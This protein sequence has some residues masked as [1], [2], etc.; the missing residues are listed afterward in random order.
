MSA[1]TLDSALC[2]SATSFLTA[3]MPTAL[4]EKNRGARR[5]AVSTACWVHLGANERTV[6]E[7]RSRKTPFKMSHLISSRT[8]TARIA[9]I[10][11]RVLFILLGATGARIGE[12]L[13]VEIDKHISPDF[14]TISIEQKLLGGVIEK[15]LKTEASLRKVDLHPDI[16]TLLKWFVGDRKSGFLFP[17]AC[18]GK[19]ISGHTALNH[20]HKALKG[21]GYEN[22]YDHSSKA[23]THIFRRFR[24]T[25][26]RNKVFCPVGVRHFWV[27]HG[28]SDEDTG[29]QDAMGELYDKIANDRPF[30]LATAEKC[31]VGFDVPS[32]VPNAPKFP[33]VRRP[34]KRATKRPS[35][36]RDK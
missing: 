25:Y 13:A 26:L 29:N 31:G 28:D 18:A 20:L 1:P 15:R 14:R 21:L 3:Q 5:S 24:I 2:V 23:G 12:M 4:L 19:P 32:D 8:D 30:R 7:S 27:G 22:D 34:C 16:S 11:Y 33:T 36:Q 17:G 35:N 6:V 10:F 9:D